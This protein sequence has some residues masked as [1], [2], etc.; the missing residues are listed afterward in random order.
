LSAWE[1]TQPAERRGAEVALLTGG[2]VKPYAY[3]LAT[4]LISKGLY[5]D[6]IGGDELDSPEFHATPN[7]TFLNLRGSQKPDASLMSKVKRVLVYYARLVRYA[8]SGE[9][10]IFHI[11]WNNKFEVVDRT[12][13]MLYYKLLGKKVVLTVHNVN[14]GRRDSTDN[15]LNRWTLGIQYRL[16]DHLFVHTHKMKQELTDTFSVREPSITVIPFGINNSVPQTRMTAVQAKH[17]LGIGARERTLLFFGR[18]APYKGLEYLVSAFQ[19]LVRERDNYRLIIA[20]E[21]KAGD[22]YWETI[23]GSISG[24]THGRIMLKIEY[25]PDEDTELYFKAAD[26]LILPYTQIF[27]SGVLFLGYSFGLPAI[28]ADVGS[29]SEDVVEGKT[30]FVFRARDSVDLGRA[31]DRYFSSELFKNLASRRE[32]IRN[33]AAER[34]SWDTVGQLTQVVYEALIGDERTT[35]AGNPR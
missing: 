3:G 14:A 4:A 20:G 17:R 19:R 13:L 9:P 22:K 26:V 15:A 33:Y 1:L 34:H 25:I 21:R 12:I 27:Q 29:L 5:L 8:T 18:I 30:G 28:V 31:I 35:G 24:V 10:D 6:L 7:V 32:Q 23:R 11:V 16:A 2:G